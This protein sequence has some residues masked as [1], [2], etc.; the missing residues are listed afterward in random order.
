M[1]T[2]FAKDYYAIF[3]PSLCFDFSTNNNNK[4]GIVIIFVIFIF[5]GLVFGLYI[6]LKFRK[7]K[8]EG[9]EFN[10]RNLK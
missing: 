4:T 9:K 3:R 6:F 5:I 10:F 8:R 2:L 1:Q 7:I